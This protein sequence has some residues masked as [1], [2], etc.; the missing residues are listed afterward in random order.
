[1]DKTSM[2]MGEALVRLVK[3]TYNTR[4]RLEAVHGR[5]LADKHT[6]K[7]GIHLNREGHRDGHA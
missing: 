6:A 5:L 7:V 1:M 4:L 2:H 3:A